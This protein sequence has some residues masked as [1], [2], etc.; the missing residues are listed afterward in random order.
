MNFARRFGTFA[1][2]ISNLKYSACKDDCFV[3]IV[4]F[5]VI[6]DGLTR[7]TS[8]V[9][10]SGSAGP[11]SA[12]GARRWVCEVWQFLSPPS[13]SLMKLPL[14]EPALIMRLW[15]SLWPRLAEGKGRP[16]VESRTL[17]ELTLPPSSPLWPP[18]A[19]LDSSPFWLRAP[20]V[21][22]LSSQMLP[23]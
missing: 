22:V 18:S 12:V 3:A 6:L 19:V 4:R 8:P 16:R 13:P 20:F 23:P 14:A 11:I 7:R 5:V 2:T 15:H 1:A 21:P 10:A 9:W 17:S